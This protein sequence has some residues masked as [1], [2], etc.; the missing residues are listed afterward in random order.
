MSL[1]PDTEAVCCYTDKEYTRPIFFGSMK[2][3]LRE[4]ES[5]NKFNED[6]IRTLMWSK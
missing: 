6:W 4:A 1:Y 3:L 2:S 5:W